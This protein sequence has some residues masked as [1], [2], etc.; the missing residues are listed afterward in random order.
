MSHWVPFCSTCPI[1]GCPEPSRVIHWSHGDDNNFEDINEE[2]Y[3]KCRKNGCSMNK[4]PCFIL[5]LLFKCRNHPNYRQVQKMEIYNALSIISSGDLG[6]STSEA[7]NLLN[8]IL[9]S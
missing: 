6:L 8:K 9:N 1:A 7:K 5:Y 3:V 2:G 4:Y